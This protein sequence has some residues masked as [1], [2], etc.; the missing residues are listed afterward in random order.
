[1]K[2]VIFVFAATITALSTF[3][4][5][6]SEALAVLN[7]MSNKYKKI[8][9]FE[10]EFVQHMS[11]EGAGID[12][13]IEGQITVKGDMYLLKVAGQEIYNNGTDVY[14]YSKEIQEVT[15]DTFNPDE[16]EITLGNIYDLY[17]EGFKYILISTE[18]NGNRI[19]ELD[20]ETNNKSYFKIRLVIDKNDN[21]KTFTVFEKGG[22][23]YLYDIK[24][25]KEVT[26]ND[27]YFT[28]DTSKH[29]DVE[30]IDFR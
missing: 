9:S 30:V 5:Y 14:S 24:N 7:A 3:A 26:L 22:T 20:P 25:F 28:F 12:E 13:S 4:Q 17:K 23:K 15:I 27:S 16:Q 10:A 6:D 8:G 2:K 1:M 21:L 19:V 11:N 29:P 18:S